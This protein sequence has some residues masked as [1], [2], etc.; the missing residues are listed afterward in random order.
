M[1]DHGV[2][3]LREWVPISVEKIK[4]GSPP[5]L[6]VKAKSTTGD[7]TWEGEFNTVIV[8]IGRDPCTADLKLDNAGIN[9]N[10]K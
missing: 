10:T 2:K 7:G 5:T 1:T 6:L 4:D 3:F 8:A 9:V